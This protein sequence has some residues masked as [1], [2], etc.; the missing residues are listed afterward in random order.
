MSLIVWYQVRYWLVVSCEDTSVSIVYILFLVCL[1]VCLFSIVMNHC[2]VYILAGAIWQW[3][4]PNVSSC[5]QYGNQ[6]SLRQTSSKHR[7]M[8]MYTCILMP[9][10]IKV[11]RIAHTPPFGTFPWI[12]QFFFPL[13]SQTPKS[14]NLEIFKHK[15]ARN[16][17]E[18]VFLLSH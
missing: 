6:M 4:S 9:M 17:L 11:K 16:S 2:I 5:Q 10:L 1:F 7:K 18:K 12:C 14:L 13:T 15:L 3:A 8:M